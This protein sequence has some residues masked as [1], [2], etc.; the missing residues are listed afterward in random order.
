VNIVLTI[1]GIALGVLVVFST[2]A[3][4]VA[5]FYARLVKDLNSLDVVIGD[6]SNS[7]SVKN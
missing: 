4:L 6:C 7:E 3:L 1:P 5:A 2:I